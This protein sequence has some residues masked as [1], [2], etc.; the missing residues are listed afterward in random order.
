VTALLDLVETTVGLR[1]L[2][3]TLLRPR[4]SEAL[5]DE[6]AFEQEEYLPYWAE[7][8]PSGLALARSLAPRRLDGQHVVE[9]GC[10]LAVPSIVAALRGAR[11]LATDWSVDAIVL[12]ALNA[13]RNGARL[14]T[15]VCS[16]AEPDAIAEAGPFD[17][18]VAADVLYER[19]NVEQLLD[20]LPRL[21]GRRG[22]ALIADPGRPAT[23]EFLREA[24][25]GWRIE[26]ERDALAPR[27]A[28][29]RLQRRD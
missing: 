17:L 28:L 4:D 10:G 1:E 21:T 18:V 13:R 25:H 9:L 27:I 22:E 20:A 23:A 8:W 6:T 11:V 12:V 2:Q 24:E 26:T 29:H 3:L 15:C 5:L 7:L 14:D 16:W 19:R